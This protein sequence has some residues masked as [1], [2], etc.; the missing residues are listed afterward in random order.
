MRTLHNWL[1][2]R[3]LHAKGM[4]ISDLDLKG[5]REAQWSP[6]FEDLM[7]GYWANMRAAPVP[8]PPWSH[9]FIGLMKERLVQGACRYGLSDDP[10][11]RH[12][13][14][15]DCARDRY[16]LYEETGDTELLVDVANMMLLTFVEGN[17]PKAFVPQNLFTCHGGYYTD[18]PGSYYTIHGDKGELVSI[19]CTMMQEFVQGGHPN[20]H[21]GSVGDGAE[22][23]RT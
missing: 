7:H 3:I 10:D 1:Y 5:V 14:C 6:R 2:E 18:F 13:K 16:A 4:P 12:F 22:K 9:R 23:A 17:H 15:L 20:A 8:A 11:K 21:F 19:A